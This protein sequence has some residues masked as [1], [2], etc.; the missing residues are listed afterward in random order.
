MKVHYEFNLFL[1]LEL[2]SMKSRI[3]E[4]NRKYKVKERATEESNLN[5]S[6]I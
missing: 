2:N 1:T 3:K 5:I 6:L 4:P